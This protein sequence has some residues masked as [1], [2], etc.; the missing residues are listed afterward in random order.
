MK[1][2]KRIDLEIGKTQVV[3]GLVVVTI[4]AS[5]AIYKLLDR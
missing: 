2:T 5:T 4:I 1:L 3:I